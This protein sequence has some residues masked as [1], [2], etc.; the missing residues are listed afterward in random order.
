[1]ATYYV[2]KTGNDDTGDGSTESPW[3]TISKALASA[4]FGGH[5]ILVG[6]GTYAE[7]SGD[8]YWTINVNFSTLVTIAPESGTYGG[9]IFR[10]ASPDTYD[11][12]FANAVNLT[13]DK[14]DF[15]AATTPSRAMLLI[16]GALL[17]HLYFTN[18]NVAG[19]IEINPTSGASSADIKFDTCTLNTVNQNSATVTTNG[20]TL[21]GCTIANGAGIDLIRASNVLIESCDI[22]N[23]AGSYTLKLGTEETYSAGAEYLDTVTVKKCTIAGNN[24][25]VFA[26]AR[27][28]NVTIGGADGDGNTITS[29]GYGIILKEQTGSTVSY[30]TVTNTS[31]YACIYCKAAL[32]ATISHNTLTNN[33]GTTFKVGKGD[34]NLC[35]DIDFQNNS[36]SGTGS[37][38]LFYWGDSSHDAGGGVCDYNVYSAGGSAKFGLVRSDT[39]VQTICE[40]IE[41][42]AGYDVT[43]NDRHSHNSG[44]GIPLCGKYMLFSK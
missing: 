20:I 39:D 14:I 33:A 40:L 41:A 6:D 3:L 15:T 16:R 44:E 21:T 31:A 25:V 26:G 2:R 19:V 28:K 12:V 42:W 38:A 22:S 17:N 9:V 27:S 30:N 5:T 11:I 7:N 32:N 24:H 10:A 29:T 34:S 18:C 8:G 23:T 36:V 13:F 35:S 1:M 43:G 37:N 4:G